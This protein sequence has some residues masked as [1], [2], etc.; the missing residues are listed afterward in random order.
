MKEKSIRDSV[1]RLVHSLENAAMKKILLA[2]IAAALVTAPAQAKTIILA[3]SSKWAISF[4]DEGCR[5]ARIFGEGDN[6]TTM[7][8]IRRRPGSSGDYMVLAGKPVGEIQERHGVE[9]G[10]GPGTDVNET[11]PYRGSLGEIEP[12]LIFSSVSIRP[13]NTPSRLD[14]SEE[15]QAALRAESRKL[16]DGVTYMIVADRSD[17]LRFDFGSMKE[18]NTVMDDCANGLIEAWGLDAEKHASAMREPVPL[19][20]EDWIRTSDYPM[21]MVRAGQP[22]IVNVR[23]IVG[24]DG[25]PTEC[26][27]QST[28]RPK[29]FD[30]AVCS[31]ILKRADF[32]PALDAAGK[33][34]KS[35]HQ[36]TVHFMIP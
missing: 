31:S 13:E 7:V 32:D 29:A 15:D 28:T 8:M 23:I 11:S 12:V 30:D 5:L 34:M 35:F 6:Q 19:N 27:I 3:P 25:S 21:K 24:A 20:A 16:A 4:D 1:D 36:T 18:V 17:E 14:Q 9:V 26:H 33:P 22:A 10:F 2:S